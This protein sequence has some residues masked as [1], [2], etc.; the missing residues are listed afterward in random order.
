MNLVT[1]M[2]CLGLRYV[3]CIDVP[4]IYFLRPVGDLIEQSGIIPLKRLIAPELPT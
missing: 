1:V 4:N 3:S 2:I